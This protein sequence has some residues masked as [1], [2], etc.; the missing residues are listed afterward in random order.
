MRSVVDYLHHCRPIGG[1][2]AFTARQP[3]NLHKGFVGVVYAAILSSFGGPSAF[4]FKQPFG[5]AA[6]VLFVCHSIYGFSWLT[7]DLFYP[8]ASWMKPGSP[9]GV[10]AVFIYPLGVY[11]LPM[12]CLVTSSLGAPDPSALCPMPFARGDEPWV[13]GGGLVCYLVGFL[14]HFTA[15]AQKYF[16]LREQRPRRL[17]T[18]GMFTYTRN[19]N[20]FGE[21]LIYAG[22]ALWSCNAVVLPLF[23]TVWLL[24]FVPNMLAKD[25][26]MSRHPGWRAW[27]DR[28]NLLFPSPVAM[29]RDYARYSLSTLPM[30]VTTNP[31]T[32]SG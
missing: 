19:P 23:A 3:I 8:D 32:K 10:V 9:L 22:F 26:S 31:W 18:D 7:K 16:V 2:I 1:P 25:A 14:Y 28:T 6:L 12:W 24:V 13:V 11:Y 20:Y 5:P 30:G 27:A 15:D 17:I 29:A 4:T 21:V